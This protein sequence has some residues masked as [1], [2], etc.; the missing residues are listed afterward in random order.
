MRG[1]YVFVLA[2]LWFALVPHPD[3]PASHP[4]TRLRERWL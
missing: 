4:S 2:K 3:H 1:G